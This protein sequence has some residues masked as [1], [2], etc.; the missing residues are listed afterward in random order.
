[1]SD[2]S[3]DLPQL[4]SDSSGWPLLTHLSFRAPSAGMV[5][6]TLEPLRQCAYLQEFVCSNCELSGG[7]DMLSALPGLT[8]ID[9]HANELTGS[10]PDE[11]ASAPSLK[12]LQLSQNHLAGPVPLLRCPTLQLLDLS[13][14]GFNGTMVDR[15]EQQDLH[16]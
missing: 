7:I 2:V 15:W 13:F 6:G 3:L 9:V 8:I 10:V 12:E 5:G 11:W 14:N 1:M 4:C 16:R